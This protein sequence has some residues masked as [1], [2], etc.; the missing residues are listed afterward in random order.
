[1]F[2]IFDITVYDQIFQ[3]IHIKSHLRYF[4]CFYQAQRLQSFP[5]SDVIDAEEAEP[6]RR[7]PVR[8]VRVSAHGGRDRSTETNPERSA[9]SCQTGFGNDR[10]RKV[11]PQIGQK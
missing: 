5:T 4:T 8:Q 2:Y 1:M 11:E 7:Q 10:T 3:Q 9:G 6:H